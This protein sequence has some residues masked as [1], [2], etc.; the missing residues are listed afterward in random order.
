VRELAPVSAWALALG[1]D[2][3]FRTS[4]RFFVPRIGGNTGYMTTFQTVIG[5]EPIFIRVSTLAAEGTLVA[6]R[7]GPLEAFPALRVTGGYANA[8]TPDFFGRFLYTRPFLTTGLVARARVA[9]SRAFFVEG[10][11]GADLDL[12]RSRYARADGTE[13]F[14]SGPFLWRGAVGFGFFVLR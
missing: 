12:V 1:A 2:I 5:G 4:N 9:L 14:T 3:A 10:E 6:L 7:A 8:S 11:A 13:L